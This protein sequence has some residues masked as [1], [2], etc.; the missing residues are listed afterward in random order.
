LEEVHRRV[1]AAGIECEAAEVTF[2]PALTVP[3]AV[4]DTPSVQKLIELLEDHD[5]V[6]DVYS[7]ADFAATER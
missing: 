5:D 4:A 6:K 7:T 2:L 3:V 1:E